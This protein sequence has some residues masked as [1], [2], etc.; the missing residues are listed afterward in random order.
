MNACAKTFASPSGEP[1][2]TRPM[3]QQM[4]E[5]IW[6]LPERTCCFVHEG[7]VS[8]NN[9]VQWE[10]RR[11]Q[12]PQE[13]RRFSSA[14]GQSA[15]LSSCRWARLPLLWQDPPRTLSSLRGVTVLCCR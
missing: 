7:V 8:N 14:G 6:T 2:T 9:A 4:C 3:P 5:K 12:I 15:D 11:F 1:S 13:A 10:G